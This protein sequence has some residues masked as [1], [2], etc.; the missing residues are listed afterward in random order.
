MIKLYND[1]LK[2]EKS[3][4]ARYLGY[5]KTEPD[6]AV[7]KLICEKINQLKYDLKVCYLPLSVFK[8]QNGRIEFDCFSIESHDLSKFIGDAQKV[9]LFCASLGIEFDRL[10]KREMVLSTSG[11]SVLQAVGTS[12]IEALCDRFCG[13]FNAKARFSPG[14]GDLD[15]SVQK[16][17]FKVLN[18]EKNIGVT[19]TD[20]FLMT[21]TKS[22]TA[23]FVPGREKN[24]D[25]CSNCDKKE[26]CTFRKV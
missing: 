26:T 16:D 4:V 6:E 2:I 17:I 12:A 11:A 5:G 9:I 10:L 3:E 19:L 23:F 1:E 18:P 21:P 15:V 8:N 24:C 20:S 7:K 25:T 14:Y 13:E 22:V